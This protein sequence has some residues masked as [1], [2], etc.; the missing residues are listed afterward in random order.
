MAGPGNLITGILNSEY[1]YIFAENAMHTW[2][3]MWIFC[4][5]V[6]IW[7]LRVFDSFYALSKTCFCTIATVEITTARSFAVSLGSDPVLLTWDQSKV[8]TRLT[9]LDA[10]LNPLV[11]Q[12]SGPKN[13]KPQFSQ[14]DKVLSFN[15]SSWSASWGAGA[16]SRLQRLKNVMEFSTS[17]IFYLQTCNAPQK[18]S[19]SILIT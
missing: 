6:K 12:F 10:G 4:M 16:A 18:I 7:N 8:L 3:C 2:C 15:L 11:S 14:T 19:Q 17:P 13:Y 1:S 9:L 5:R